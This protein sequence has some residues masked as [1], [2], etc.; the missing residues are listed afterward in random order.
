[1]QSVTGT[2][3]NS[4]KFLTKF[5]IHFL[6]GPPVLLLDVSPKDVK[7]HVHKKTY[8][9]ISITIIFII[10]INRK[11]PGASDFLFWADWI[12]SWN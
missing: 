5:H 3:G 8:L 11:Q 12:S 1:M 2:L 10:A 4:L 9:Q 7:N 6:H